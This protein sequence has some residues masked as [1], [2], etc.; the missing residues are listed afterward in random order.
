MNF[1]HQLN[2]AQISFSLAVIALVLVYA[3]F[4]RKSNKPQHRSKKS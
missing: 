3:V 1:D 2:L 4:Y